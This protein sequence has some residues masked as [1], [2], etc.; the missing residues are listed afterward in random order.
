MRRAAQTPRKRG[1]TML[2]RATV[3]GVP[4]GWQTAPGGVMGRHERGR[5]VRVEITLAGDVS[6]DAG[7]ATGR[8]V[9][10]GPPRVVL[11]ALA[12]DHPTAV[13]RERLSDIVW[14]DGQPRTWA[15]AL[16]T[17]VSRVRTL[18]STAVGGGG[19]TVVSGDAGYQLVLPAGISVAVD[20]DLAD[21]ALA[22][23]RRA[24]PGDPAH[25]LD[26]AAEAADRVRAPVLPG[27][28]GRWV[29]DVRARFD[30][31]LVGAL[32]LTSRAA[33]ATGDGRRAV[34][35]AEEAVRREPLRESAHRSLMAALGGAGDRAQ[36]LRAYQ[37]LRRVLAEELGIDPSAETE[38]AYLDL[39][40]PPAPAR[41][42]AAAAAAAS[43]DGDPPGAPEA[44]G[45]HAP[46][47]FVGRRA[48]LAVLAAAWEQAAG[49]GRHVVVVTGEAG[50]GKSRL[51]TEAAR[52]IAQAGGLVLFGRCDQEAI[53]PYQPVVEALDGLVAATP[54]DELPPLGD[55]A[56]AELATVLP[57][58]DAPRRPDRADRARLFG[59]VTDLVAAVARARPLLLVLD[60]LQ[61]ADDDTLLLVRH[62]LRRAGDAP[63]LVVAISRDHDLEPDHA[64]ADVV[65]ALD[66][67]GWVRRLALQ[68]L[69]ETEVRE[70]L[71]H[72]RPE[73][74]HAAAARRLV[75]ET[76]GNPFLVTELAWSGGDPVGTGAIPQGVHDL[77]STRLARLDPPA[78][79]LLRAGAVAGARFELDLA[80]R[81]A[82][83]DD[84]AL[85]DAADTALASGLVVEETADRYR[86][87]HDIVR[88]TL[89]AQLSGA[90]RRAL[91]RRTADALEALRAGSTDDHVAVLA[92]HS[93]AGAD[94]GGDERAVRWAR[95]AAAAA[96]ERSAPAEAVR[97]CRQALAHVPSGHE[98]LRAE[99]VTDLGVALLAAGE[100]AGARTLAE[101]AG[102][103]RRHDRPD[104]LGR[105][106]SAL[107]DAADERPELRAEA[108]RLVAAAVAAADS[109]AGTAA[110]TGTGTTTTGTGGGPDA[111]TGTGTATHAG[112]GAGTATGAGTVHGAGGPARDPVAHARLLVR[113]VRLAD[114]RSVVRP[115][116]A[117]MRALHERIGAITH[118]RAA[119][120]RLRL[121]A[122]LTVLARAAG[123]PT[124]CLLA[125]HEHAMAA[126][127]LGDDATVR[128]QLATV[129]GL[130]AAHGDA[131]GAAVV[132]ERSVSELTS[133][134]RLD[135]A[136]T[137]L[138]GAVAAVAAHRGPG[139][140]DGADA[141]AA[142]HG[143]VIDWLTG[144]HAAPDDPLPALPD[145]PAGPEGPQRLLAL[146]VAALA[147]CDAGDA[148]RAA[149]VRS[150]LAPY[151][152]LVCCLGYRTFAGAASFHLGRLAALA[153]DWG[154]A[155]RHLLA[156]LR[157]HSAWR[158]RAWVALTQ[159][160]LA[161]VLDARGRP[162]DREWI[163]GLRAE[164]GWLTSTLGLRR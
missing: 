42:P 49:G 91:H 87:P 109:P 10:T 65:H 25:A 132:A 47:P 150:L 81:A 164:S 143:T 21:Q 29:D 123:D 8:R 159:A 18:V 9:L 52:R 45:A 43:G 53:V 117:A 113:Q 133:D 40:G 30:A 5:G 137:A 46:A 103:A 105:A 155:E 93:S 71:A 56:L 139:G 125:A 118:P 129:A 108:R 158:A 147:A 20:L 31:V 61:W 59:A 99:V 85:L 138:Q 3:Q 149:E 28:H 73:G 57:S 19:E 6:V 111:T 127:T 72:L 153:G 122:E 2:D 24:L 90:R 114:A 142:R 44:L 51:T 157:V 26:L 54:A 92:H 60:D 135:E 104:V 69:G 84:D 27:H 145:G 136:R 148:E 128:A 100:P 89:V 96:A 14:P 50:I 140:P 95:R 70:L 39:L 17:H 23:A 134:G 32:E 106:A 141:V 12:L 22:A 83:L 161:D 15:S 144:E 35:A 152:D 94:A 48:E 33:T 66:R 156:A 76:A 154:D 38:S 151:A 79:E 82:G 98:G 77:V 160:A 97:L 102:L 36:A 41:A 67:D 7:D 62:L 68:G 146:G 1:R 58:L 130:A 64:L 78:V 107:A 126:A 13:P 101:G 74:D 120:Q 110:G 86:F 119:D 37:R 34:A 75:A 116:A 63:V 124:M 80:G 55:D 121:A 4:G 88:R 162:S 115:S 112:T 163:E 131:F 16:R 11:A